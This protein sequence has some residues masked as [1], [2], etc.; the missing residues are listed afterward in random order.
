MLRLSRRTNRVCLFPAACSVAPSSSSPKLPFR[1]YTRSSRASH[2]C[3]GFISL[4][5]LSRPCEICL[6][7]PPSTAHLWQFTDFAPTF[8]SRI[9]HLYIVYHYKPFVYSSNPILT[10]G[11]IPELKLQPCVLLTLSLQRAS[12]PQACMQ[13][14]GKQGLHA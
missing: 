7:S 4:D 9:V 11:L 5:L 8:D 2:M 12:T 3:E 14:A 1:T 6:H 10:Y 13:S